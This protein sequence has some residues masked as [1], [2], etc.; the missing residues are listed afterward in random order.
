MTPH[1]WHCRRCRAFAPLQIFLTHHNNRSLCGYLGK[2]WSFYSFYLLFQFQNII[3][4]T[5]GRGG[6]HDLT[7]H[8]D[9]KC[10]QWIH[11][12]HSLCRFDSKFSGAVCSSV[13]WGYKQ[14]LQSALR[15]SLFA[16]LSVVYSLCVAQPLPCTHPTTTHLPTLDKF[17]L[18]MANLPQ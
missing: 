7:I 3:L 17:D 4:N 13:G 18:D 5:E 8:H 16:L 12:C 9:E 10:Q 15:N 6:Q 11:L 2:F 1:T 14:Y